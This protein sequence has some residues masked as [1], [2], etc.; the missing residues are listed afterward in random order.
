MVC[1]DFAAEL[2]EECGRKGQNIYEVMNQ[3]VEE[4]PVEEFCRFICRF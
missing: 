3:W 1:K 2:K 4:I